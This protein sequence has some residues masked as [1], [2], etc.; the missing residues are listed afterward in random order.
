M[1]QDN[2][3]PLIIE[4]LAREM[5]KHLRRGDEPRPTGYAFYLVD[6]QNDADTKHK[7]A[8][9]ETFDVLQDRADYDE[10]EEL[11]RELTLD[12]DPDGIRTRMAALAVVGPR[13]ALPLGE[14]MEG[15]GKSDIF[16]AVYLED[17]QGRHIARYMPEDPYVPVEEVPAML[18]PLPTGGL[19]EF[20]NLLDIEAYGPMT[21]VS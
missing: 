7:M 14:Y 11:V 10:I 6:A 18:R 15:T 21:V 1:Y 9:I 2:E 17:V 8:R 3:I 19:R 20:P 12:D 13:S 5:Q 16:L 4:A